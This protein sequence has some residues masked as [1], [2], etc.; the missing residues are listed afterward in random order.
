[1][2][3]P[4]RSVLTTRR[5]RR[6]ICSRLRFNKVERS[7]LLSSG[8]EWKERGGGGVLLSFDRLAFKWKLPP[9]QRLSL[10][11]P[12]KIAIIEKNKKRAGD[13]GKREKAREPLFSLSPSHRAPRLFFFYLS[14]LPTCNLVP[15]AFLREKPW[16]RG[17]PTCTTQRGL[18]RGERS[19]SSCY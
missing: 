10:G 5:S 18:C 6:T 19:G 7:Y 1:M 12:I 2:Q 15:R 13:D 9:P 14:S 8:R 16:G 3:R 4:Q 17:C 11:I